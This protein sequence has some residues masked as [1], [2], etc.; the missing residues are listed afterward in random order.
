M[1]PHYCT[2]LWWPTL[3]EED[4]HS[5]G[6][7]RRFMRRNQGHLVGNVQKALVR[8][9]R[10]QQ[11]L[12]DQLTVFV[13]SQ[14]PNDYVYQDIERSG[15][16][17]RPFQV[18]TKGYWRP[19]WF[20]LQTLNK[21]PV[22]WFDFLDAEVCSKFTEDESEFLAKQLQREELVCEFT[23]Y[24][25]F[26]PPLHLVSGKNAGRSVVQPHTGIFLLGG[27]RLVEFAI[28]THV[29]HDQIALARV[30]EEHHGL[31]QDTAIPSELLPYSARGLFRTTK[32]DLRLTINARLNLYKPRITHKVE[33][34]EL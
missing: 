21:W 19:K 22:I 26:G 3:F 14:M 13:D 7:A 6:T 17:T 1:N 18:P 29:D 16:R 12:G 10:T 8:L 5:T 2:A 9:L 28:A 11:L 20:A 27:P 33:C 24:R 25:N 23:R 32:D 15:L 4:A 31:F 30:L 34:H